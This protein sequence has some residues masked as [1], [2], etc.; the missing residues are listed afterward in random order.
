MWKSSQW[1]KA[2]SQSEHKQAFNNSIC[3]IFIGW[4]SIQ[5]AAMTLQFIL[6][7]IRSKIMFAVPNW[8]GALA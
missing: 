5:T 7:A 8:S 4:T 1:F 6:Q 3:F 2:C